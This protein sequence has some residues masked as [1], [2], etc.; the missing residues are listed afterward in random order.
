MVHPMHNGVSSGIQKRRALCNKSEKI[1]KTFP[2]FTHRKHFV[3]SIS[4]QKE[5]LTEQ[6]QEPV[7]KKKQ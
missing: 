1:K 7:C 2:E 3:G 5:G 4:M 6:R